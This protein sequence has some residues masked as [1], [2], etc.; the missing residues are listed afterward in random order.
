MLKG[1]RYI[2]AFDHLIPPD[3]EWKLFKRAA[4]GI[5]ACIYRGVS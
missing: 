4:E 1:G 2:A 5:K 3:A